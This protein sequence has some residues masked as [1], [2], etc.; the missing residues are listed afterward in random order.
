MITTPVY[1]IGSGRLA[2]LCLTCYKHEC[3]DPAYLVLIDQSA[4]YRSGSSSSPALLSPKIRRF[5]IPVYCR[6]EF[7]DQL[8]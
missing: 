7:V 6:P 5:L 2:W 3:R 4:V 1:M 8:G